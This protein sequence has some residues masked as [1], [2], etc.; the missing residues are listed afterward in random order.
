M[1]IIRPVVI[2][3][4]IQNDYIYAIQKYNSFALYDFHW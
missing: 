4:N 1:T 3:F 2:R